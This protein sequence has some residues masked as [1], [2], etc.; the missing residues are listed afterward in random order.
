[1]KT[2]PLINFAYFPDGIDGRTGAQIAGG[3]ASVQEAQDLAAILRA[4]TLPI[5]LK[6]IRQRA[7]T[8]NS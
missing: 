1:V 8:Q 3:F 7:L 6:L 5:K 2:R 4:G